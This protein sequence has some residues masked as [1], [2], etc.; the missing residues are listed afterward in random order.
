M[1]KNL[2]MLV[3][4]VMLAVLTSPVSAQIASQSFV[5]VDF[6][7]DNLTDAKLEVAETTFSEPGL[8]PNHPLYPLKRG[9][10]NIRLLLT[11]GNEKKAELHQEFAKTRLAEV[12]KL[13]E[14]NNTFDVKRSL[15]EFDRELNDSEN[16]Y[17]KI[18]KNNSVTTKAREDFMIQSNLVLGSVLKKV[19]EQSKPSIEKVLNR[20]GERKLNIKFRPANSENTENRTENEETVKEKTGT[21]KN[22]PEA[23]KKKTERSEVCIQ[24]ITPA[25]SPSGECKE[26]PTPCD[27]PRGW[28][29]VSACE[30]DTT[31]KKPEKSGESTM[32]SPLDVPSKV[33]GV[34][35][36]IGL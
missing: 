32:K 14:E 30:P 9:F 21:E 31:Q 22:K 7:D 34:K 6:A 29:K 2:I 5:H 3:Q 23:V 1:R 36:I 4:M 20:S 19:P 16:L 26:F 28:K 27:V 24:V 8:L 35:K 18:R 13:V 25:I 17:V 33:P 11:F 12:K 10:E 15:D